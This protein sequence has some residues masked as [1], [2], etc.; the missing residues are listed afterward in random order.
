LCSWSWRIIYLLLVL[1]GFPLS[2]LSLVS[3]HFCFSYVLVPLRRCSCFASLDYNL[4]SSVL[5]SLILYLKT[6][7]F[8]TLER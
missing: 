3:Y 5:R 1:H 2:L 4:W 6:D 7:Q 8:L